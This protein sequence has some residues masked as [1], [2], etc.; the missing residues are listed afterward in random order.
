MV[1]HPLRRKLL[2]GKT[3]KNPFPRE[4]VSI[5]VVW[6]EITKKVITNADICSGV[7]MKISFRELNPEKGGLFSPYY[8]FFTATS[9]F[10]FVILS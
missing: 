8:H 2:R 3:K 5:W 6:N 10:L 9:L 4:K 1:G 7:R